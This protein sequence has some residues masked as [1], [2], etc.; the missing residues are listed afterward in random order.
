[1]PQRYG[2]ESCHELI[3]AR[4]TARPPLGF[5]NMLK[6]RAIGRARRRSAIGSR[7]QTRPVPWINDTVFHGATAAWL[8]CAKITGGSDHGRDACRDGPQDR[9]AFR[10]RGSAGLWRF[11]MGGSHAFVRMK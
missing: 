10:L 5:R 3:Q 7:P 1:M 6:F 2:E 11:W 9:R 8:G 4:T